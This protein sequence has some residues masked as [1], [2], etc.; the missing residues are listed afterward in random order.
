MGIR[1]IGSFLRGSRGAKIAGGTALIC[2]ISALSGCGYKDVNI[3]GNALASSYALIRPAAE[4]SY[5]L[6]LEANQGIKVSE[7]LERYSVTTI[8]AEELKI[9]TDTLNSH[10]TTIHALQEME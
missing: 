5:E 4:L 7:F 3:A 8:T 1:N 6:R 2:A 9:F 10:Y